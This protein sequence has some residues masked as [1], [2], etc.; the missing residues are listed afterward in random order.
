MKHNNVKYM[1][2]SADADVQQIFEKFLTEKKIKK[3]VALT[4][5]LE[6]FMIATDEELYLKLKKESLNV[7]KVKDRIEQ[8]IS[9]N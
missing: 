6:I 9:Q 3:S 8:E 5:F 4:D 1:S 2:I 7:E